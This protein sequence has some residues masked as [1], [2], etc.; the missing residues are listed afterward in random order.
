MTT[1]PWCREKVIVYYYYNICSV[2]DQY[3]IL[4]I[5]NSC[6]LIHHVVATHLLRHTRGTVSRLESY[7][8]APCSS[9]RIRSFLLPFFSVSVIYFIIDVPMRNCLGKH[10]C[11]SITFPIATLKDTYSLC[12]VK[13]TG[14]TA[15][16]N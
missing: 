11:M 6:L 3:N 8:P 15:L 2:C 5:I 14:S 7:F 10:L 9:F 12:S 4:L 16:I 13:R 1:P